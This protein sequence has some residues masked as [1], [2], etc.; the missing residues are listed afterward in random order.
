MPASVPTLS[1][2][3]RYDSVNRQRFDVVAV[4]ERAQA[5][6]RHFGGDGVDQRVFI[7]DRRTGC[8]K[9][10]LHLFAQ[11]V[12]RRHDDPDPLSW[13]TP[14]LEMLQESIELSG[15]RLIGRRFRCAGGVR[16]LAGG[17]RRDQ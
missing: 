1:A 14:A 10:C 9:R 4:G 15:I 6:D 12:A 3:A 5:A 8:V 7:H 2:P 16:L 17:E 13:L 11:P